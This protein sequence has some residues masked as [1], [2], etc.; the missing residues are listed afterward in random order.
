MAGKCQLP[1]CDKWALSGS[2]FCANREISTPSLLQL[3]PNL[4]TD[5]PP[6]S[7]QRPG[8]EFDIDGTRVPD[9]ANDCWKSDAT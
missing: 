3:S 8:V 2:R 7:Q 9:F 1:G 4:I 5:K 6:G